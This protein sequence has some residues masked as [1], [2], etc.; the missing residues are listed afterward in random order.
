LYLPVAVLI[1]HLHRCGGMPKGHY[2]EGALCRQGIMA[3]GHY[4]EGALCRRGIMPKGHYA[5]GALFRRGIMSK[6][7]WSHIA[8]AA[9]LHRYSASS[10]ET[11]IP[12][13]AKIEQPAIV[14]QPTRITRLPS[15]KGTSNHK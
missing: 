7:R 1:H 14:G 4:F 5:E 10:S 12:I 11:G 13:A 2:F 9:T 8:E 15:R 6:A 3:K